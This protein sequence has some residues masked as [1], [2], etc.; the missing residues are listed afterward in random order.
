MG[1]IPERESDSIEIPITIDKIQGREAEGSNRTI[2]AV[3]I[4]PVCFVLMY[5]VMTSGSNSTL[6]GIIKAGFILAIGI[7][8]FRF[9]IMKEKYYVE[10]TKVLE[11]NNYVFNPKLYW[12]IYEVDKDYPYVCRFKNGNIGIFVKMEKGLIIDKSIGIEYEHYEGISEAL[13]VL[14]ELDIRVK[15]LDIMDSL[16]N[17]SRLESLYDSLYEYKSPTLKDIYTEIFEYN[18]ALMKMNYTCD[19]Y[20]CIMIYNKPEDEL[21]YQAQKFLNA[22]LNANYVSYTVLDSLALRELPII[23]FNFDEFSVVNACNMVYKQVTE[24][25]YLTPISLINN[26]GEQILN[27]TSAEKSAEQKIRSHEKNRKKIK[28][29]KIEDKEIDLFTEEE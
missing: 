8:I 3:I 25:Q 12:G 18:E 7:I 9:V 23:T 1:Y 22:L 29:N 4:F 11:E 26:E 24:L 27:K 19:D 16:G 14:G 21:W 15:H 13:R 28:Y 17:D 10:E 20:F 5:F 6:G 2:G